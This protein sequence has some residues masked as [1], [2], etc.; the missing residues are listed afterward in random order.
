MDKSNDYEKKNV[1]LVT[2]A[3]TLVIEST[4]ATILLD[5]HEKEK[6]NLVYSPDQDKYVFFFIHPYMVASKADY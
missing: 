5:P 2:W 4:D 1:W 6:T 3:D